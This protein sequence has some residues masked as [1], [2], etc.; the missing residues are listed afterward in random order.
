MSVLLMPI[1]CLS[2][3]PVHVEG[4]LTTLSVCRV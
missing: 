2:S 1:D 4:V 3:V